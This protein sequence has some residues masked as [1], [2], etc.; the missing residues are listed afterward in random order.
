MKAEVLFDATPFWFPGAGV[1]NA[2]TR[3]FAALRASDPEIDWV[4]YSRCLRSDSDVVAQL[5]GGARSL[6]V[7]L[8]RF[9]EPWIYRAAWIE[10]QARADLYHAT[11]HFLPVNAVDE[12]LIITIHDLFFLTTPTSVDGSAERFA[13]CVPEQIARAGHVIAV[14]AFTKNAICS[15]FDIPEQRVSV[16]HWGVDRQHFNP[17]TDPEPGRRRL[18]MRWEIPDDFLLSVGC[19]LGRKNTARLLLAHRVYRSRGGQLP[20]VLAWSP[21]AE[22]RA[23]YRVDCE[24]GHMV[25][26]ED[27]DDIALVDLMRAARAVVYPSLAE[28]FGMVVLEAMACG[29]PVITSKTTSLPE[30]GG[31]APLFVDPS[32]TEEI[33]AA[34]AAVEGD[35]LVAEMSRAGLRRC[36]GFTWERTARATL[37]VYQRVF[38]AVGP[39]ARTVRTAS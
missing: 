17:T 39:L 38:D 1:G 34:M 37:D 12:R 21:P 9:A 26:I 33:C 23:A 32:D 13:R 11:D 2:T 31:E 22:I 27:V 7:R 18:A 19:A 8:P 25:F 14:S 5:Q 28:G 3:S 4:L 29:T 15:T 16:V 10:R 30:V 35:A 36:D 20:L 24:Q 6:H